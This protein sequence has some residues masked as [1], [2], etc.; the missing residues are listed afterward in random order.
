[1]FFPEDCDFEGLSED[2]EEM[3]AYLSLTG[4][5]SATDDC[6]DD[7]MGQFQDLFQNTCFQ[8]GISD[9]CATNENQNIALYREIINL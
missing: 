2:M 4:I 7:C 8:V 9:H 3:I 6:S 1:M 5:C